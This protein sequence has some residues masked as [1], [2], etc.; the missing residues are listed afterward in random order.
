MTFSTDLG[1][2]IPELILAIGAMV[3]LVWGAFAPRM[4]FAVG[5][6]AIGVLIVAA[7]AAATGPLGRAFAGGLISDDA[8]A[9]AKVA[10]YVASA[11]C[12]PLGQ[13]WFERRGV[14]NFEFPVLILSPPSAWA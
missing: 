1:L 6:A 12:I 13:R 5:A 10:I 8:S 11:V 9:L 7:F 14:H 4:T 2:A 3:L